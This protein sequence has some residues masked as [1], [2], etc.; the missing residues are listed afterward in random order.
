MST[1]AVIQDYEPSSERP[2]KLILKEVLAGVSTALLY[3][4]GIRKHKRRTPRAQTQ[5]TVVFIHGYLANPSCFL[6]M[7]VYLRAKGHGLPLYFDYSSS[8]GIEQAAV[9]LR[10]FLKKNV[11]GG[12]IDLV[13]HSMGGLVAR[14]Y[15]QELGGSRRVDSCVTIGT[16]HKGTYNAY[17]LWSRVGHELR[18]DSKLLARIA[19]SS[20][21]S[22]SVRFLSVVAGSDNIVLP[23]VFATTTEET[24]LV[25]ETGHLGLLFSPQV[26]RVVGA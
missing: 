24:C 19:K 12:R 26:F 16:P 25:P 23:R 2:A 11:R 6:P 8:E 5:R 15:L 14:L 4:F 9:K 21:K 20:T 10:V 22:K 1:S 13:C 3:P 17:W 18:P 7:S